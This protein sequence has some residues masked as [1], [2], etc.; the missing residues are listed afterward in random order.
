MT[1][2]DIN[3]ILSRLSYKPGTSFSAKLVPGVRVDG[4]W[5]DVVNLSL[6]IQVPD[7]FSPKEKTELTFSSTTRVPECAPFDVVEAAWALV[8]QVE[9]HEAMEFF[10]LDGFM[11]RDPHAPEVTPAPEE[12]P[13]LPAGS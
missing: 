10:R 12:A 2:S 9:I 4:A 1:Q 5:V 13:S 6:T 7:A 11:V 3:A 8:K